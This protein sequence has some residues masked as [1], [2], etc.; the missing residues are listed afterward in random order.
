MVEPLI[1]EHRGRH[2]DLGS[3][4]EEFDERKPKQV[5]KRTRNVST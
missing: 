5:G 3:E 1:E 4:F 2:Q